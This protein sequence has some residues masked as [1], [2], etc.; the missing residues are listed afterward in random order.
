MIRVLD[1]AGR[2]NAPVRRVR[3][4]E[5]ATFRFRY[6]WWSSDGM[7]HGTRTVDLGTAL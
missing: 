1:P 5:Y 7:S 6:T 4:P 2:A 3:I